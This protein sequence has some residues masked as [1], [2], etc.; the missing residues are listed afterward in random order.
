MTGLVNY[1]RDSNTIITA[2]GQYVVDGRNTDPENV[3]DGLNTGSSV[4]WIAQKDGEKWLEITLG[5]AKEIGCVQF[6]NGWKSGSTWKS[7]ITN[8]KLEYFD[9]SEWIQFADF[10]IAHGADFSEEYHTYGMLWTENEVSY[11]FDGEKLRTHQHSEIHTPT[12]IYLSL[13]ILDMGIAGAVTDSIDGT[14]MKV[15]YV[16]YYDK[17]LIT[18]LKLDTSTLVLVLGESYTLTASS[19]PQDLPDSTFSWSSSNTEVVNVS[20]DGTVSAVG[21]GTACVY[22]MHDES[23]LVD[24]CQI[25]VIQDVSVTKHQTSEVKLYPNPA[26]DRIYLFN[27]GDYNR[28]KIYNLSHQLLINKTLAFKQTIDTSSLPAGHYIYSLEG[29]GLPVSG[30]LLKQ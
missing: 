6:T 10:D 25:T 19:L 11:Y 14:S 3:A 5:E 21:T 8:Y 29:R 4:S 2:S 28:I 24:S 1:T 18:E 15:D 22:A 7:L 9:G 12:H 27:I 17:K 26:R 13:A 16:R 23:G 30:I 20:K